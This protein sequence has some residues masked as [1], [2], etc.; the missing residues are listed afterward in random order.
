MD[1]RLDLLRRAAVVLVLLATPVMAY[2]LVAGA[3]TAN[4]GPAGWF[5]L[6]VVPLA[7]LGTGL[8]LMAGVSLRWPRSVGDDS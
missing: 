1:P 8:A 6:V 4:A 7:L 5:L 2:F 3:M